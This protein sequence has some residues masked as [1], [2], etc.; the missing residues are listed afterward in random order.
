[1]KAPLQVLPWHAGPW[2]RLFQALKQH[3]LPQALL[4]SGPAGCGKRDFAQAFAA[5][6]WCRAATVADG[7]C[8]T[9]PD[10]RQV[11]AQTHPNLLVLR[12]EEGKRDIRIE[13]VRELCARLA[14]TSHDG[15]PQLALIDPADALNRHAINALLKTIEEPPAH[16]HLLLLTERPLALPATLRSRCQRFSFPPPPVEQASAW[17]RA[18]V[19]PDAPVEAALTAAHGAPLKALALLSDGGL[20]KQA[21]WRKSLLDLAAGCGDPVQVAQ[22]IGEEEVAGFL[23]WLAAWMR[24]LLR[25]R[26]QGGEG[27][28]ELASLARGLSREAYESLIGELMDDLHRLEGN[29]RPLWLLEALLIRWQEI[30]LQ[31]SR[32]MSTIP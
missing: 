7:P 30:G 21:A 14:L 25:L 29:V 5:A 28:P 15:R 13:S 12:A 18:Q 20:Q 4:F 16:S 23:R 19:P 11:L 3:K 2:Q 10:C 26:A 24:D 9:C 27:D 22:S 8:G 17:L 32:T 1:M 6:L 31:A